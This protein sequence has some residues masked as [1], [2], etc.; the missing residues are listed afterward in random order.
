MN[1]IIQNKMNMFSPLEQSSSFD[2]K[3]RQTKRLPK[4]LK[5]IAI[6]AVTGV[7]C[8]SIGFGSSG[9]SPSEV[10]QFQAPVRFNPN[11]SEAE[12][13]VF[14]AHYL[15]KMVGSS[16]ISGFSNVADVWMREL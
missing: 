4:L 7:V 11:E 2:A 5:F 9:I 12:R 8:W 3:P 10:P 14:V 1:H 15:N 6:L 13:I 16:K